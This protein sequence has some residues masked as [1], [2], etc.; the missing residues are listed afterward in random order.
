M[1][2]VPGP[3]T[4]AS[5]PSAG[6]SPSSPSSSS[7]N[8]PSRTSS[9]RNSRL[10]LSTASQSMPGSSASSASSPYLPR[11]LLRS[12]RPRS[13]HRSACVGEERRLAA[14]PLRKGSP[15][16]AAALDWAAPPA[17]CCS[18]APAS[19]LG[20]QLRRRLGPRLGPQL[21]LSPGLR[22]WLRLGSRLVPPW[23]GPRL[24]SWLWPRLAVR[25]RPLWGPT[26]RPPD[27]HLSQMYAPGRGPRPAPLRPL[28]LLWGPAF[29]P[30]GCQAGAPL[31]KRVLEGLCGP[32]VQG[33]HA[34]IWGHGGPCC[35]IAG[36]LGSSGHCSDH[37]RQ[38][39]AAPAL[40]RQSAA[41]SI[42]MLFLPTTVRD[43]TPG[44]PGR[45]A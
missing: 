2:V 10:S 25:P 16:E 19:R 28:P 33:G 17:S 7:S 32:F 39:A 8:C 31:H 9:M 34:P 40:M 1:T 4:P 42:I 15:E 24:W 11:A 18:R 12:R 38:T 14:E 21:G 43:H 6:A 23:L 45:L 35:H 26:T 27:A 3:S 36:S 37:R 22:L 44:G 20:S 13:S 41:A 29:P 5:A 30:S